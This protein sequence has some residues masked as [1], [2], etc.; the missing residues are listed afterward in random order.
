MVAWEAYTYIQFSPNFELVIQRKKST[1]YKS[2]FTF[3][4]TYL[5]IEH[6]NESEACDCGGFA[7]F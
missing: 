3:A 2:S 7:V 6:L 5:T 4:I 1:S